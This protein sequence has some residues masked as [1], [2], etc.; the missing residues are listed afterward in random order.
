MTTEV[1]RGTHKEDGGYVTETLI[2]RNQ[3]EGPDNVWDDVDGDAD[4]SGAANGDDFEERL[5]TLAD[6]AAQ[7]LEAIKSKESASALHPPVL[8][9]MPHGEE[10]QP[11]ADAGE[12]IGMVE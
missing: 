11:S 3:A 9:P 2:A 6:E 5:T 10:K 4:D 12:A 1:D 8:M 7:A